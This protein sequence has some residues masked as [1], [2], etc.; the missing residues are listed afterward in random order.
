MK[1]FCKSFKLPENEFAKQ[2]HVEILNTKS[3]INWFIGFCVE[4]FNMN[5]F[6]KFIFRQLETFAK[7][8][9]NDVVT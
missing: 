3:R 5:L 9:H 2:I 6:G 8:F 4:D 1:V 7:N